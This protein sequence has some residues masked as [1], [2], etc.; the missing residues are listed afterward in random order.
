MPRACSAGPSGVRNATQTKRTP[1]SATQ[2]LQNIADE[3]ATGSYGAS[4]TYQSPRKDMV[5]IGR[6]VHL[7][8]CSRKASSYAKKTRNARAW[9]RKI[10]PLL[11]A[12]YREAGRLHLCLRFLPH[13]RAARM[14]AWRLVRLR[15]VQEV[16]Q[17]QRS[18]RHVFSRPWSSP[19]TRRER[20]EPAKEMTWKT[21]TST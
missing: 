10:A 19:G 2:R 16:G 12:S 9:R 21:T 18:P 20:L 1:C 6:Q 13:P 17:A 15:Q 7:R 5:L 8:K 4:Q 11:S 3:A 14:P